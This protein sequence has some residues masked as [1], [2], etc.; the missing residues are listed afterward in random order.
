MKLVAADVSPL[1]LHLGGSQIRL[2]SAEIEDLQEQLE[3]A[4]FPR[5]RFISESLLKTVHRVLAL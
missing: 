5:S 1:H 2:T 3:I 4:A